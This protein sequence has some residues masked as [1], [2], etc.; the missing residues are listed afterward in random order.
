MRLASLNLRP[1]C[2]ACDTQPSAHCTGTF[3]NV[4]CNCT[5]YMA[6]KSTRWDMLVSLILSVGLHRPIPTLDVY[7]PGSPSPCFVWHYSS[8][9][10]SCFD[11]DCYLSYRFFN[12]A[13]ICAVIFMKPCAST[14]PHQ[15]FTLLN[16]TVSQQLLWIFATT[17]EQLCFFDFFI[18]C[19]LNAW[20]YERGKA[21]AKCNHCQ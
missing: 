19:I 13:I 4:Q 10:L 21:E 18:P 5:M 16:T 14:D 2:A 1:A 12:G 7:S 17:S 15:I 3:C 11:N 20:L 8:P 6:N 9:Y